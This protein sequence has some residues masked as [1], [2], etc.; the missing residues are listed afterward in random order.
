VQ[1]ITGEKDK[2][3]GIYNKLVSRKAKQ[4]NLFAI[5]L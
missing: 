1:N 4:S 2:A 3:D 5:F